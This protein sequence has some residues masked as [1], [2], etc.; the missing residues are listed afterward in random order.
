MPPIQE[1]SRGELAKSIPSH[2]RSESVNQNDLSAFKEL[3]SVLDKR[4][5]QVKELKNVLGRSK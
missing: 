1:D 4:G 3:S 5:A 2:R